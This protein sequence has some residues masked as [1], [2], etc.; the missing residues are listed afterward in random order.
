M[1]RLPTPGGDAGSWGE[2]LNDFLGQEHNP[3]GT[4]KRGPDIDQAQSDIATLQT[5]KANQNALDATNANVAAVTPQQPGG[6]IV[7]NAQGKPI[8]AIRGMR[9]PEVGN[10]RFN[11][12]PSV[13]ATPPTVA[14]GLRNTSNITNAVRVAW[15]DPRL[16]I[17]GP[18]LIQSPSATQMGRPATTAMASA[19]AVEFEWDGTAIEVAVR[20][21]GDGCCCRMLVD[22][23]WVSATYEGG[24]AG[25]VGT[26]DG[27]YY[28]KY[29]FATAQPR[30]IRLYYGGRVTADTGDFD[31]FRIEATAGFWPTMQPR[32][33]RVFVMGDSWTYGTQASAHF[34]GFVHALGRALGW[35]HIL[36]SGRSGTGYLHTSGADVK[37]RDRMGTDCYPLNPDVVVLVGSI[38]DG[39]MFTKAQVTAEATALYADI[40]AHLPQAKLIVVGPQNVSGNPNQ[41]TI[42]A[43]DA[44]QAAATVPGAVDLWIDSIV[45]TIAVNNTLGWFTGTGKVTAPN[46]TGNSDRYASSDGLHPTDAGY[47]YYGRRIAQAIAAAL[48]F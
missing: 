18:N 30:H 16:R 41:N 19:Y 38:N 20:G 10:A 27:T 9:A 4:L 39:G 12:I 8:T 43:R 33:P 34:D 42:D 14:T 45:S 37:W 28:I 1:A 44:V 35:N 25:G 31:G 17:L 7:A 46:G 40:R 22:G 48:P 21:A 47:S 11:P 29:T 24:V 5:T 15:N 26:D 36:S 3:D 13:M 23:Q 6:V 32:G 2:V